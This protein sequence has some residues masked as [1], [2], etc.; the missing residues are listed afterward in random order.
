MNP[1]YSYA[2]FLVVLKTIHALDSSL[3]TGSAGINT[4]D[5]NIFEVKT[6]NY[7]VTV[8]RLDVHMTASTAPIQVWYRPGN[9]SPSYMDTYE[10]VLDT[11]I[12]GNGLNAMT[13]L[14]AFTTPIVI[15][16][17]STYT[18]Y[19]TTKTNGASTMY[20]EVGTLL[21]QAFASDEFLD[22]NEGY[23]MRYAFS[24]P[25]YPR[26]WNGVIYY[27]TTAPP[28]TPG[29]PTKNPTP[30]PTKLP[31]KQP[32]NKPTTKSPTKKPVILSS[33]PTKKPVTMIET[34]APTVTFI[35]T[36][37]PTFNDKPPFETLNPTIAHSK[38]PISGNTQSLRPTFSDT[39]SPT[40]P[41]TTPSPTVNVVD[42]LE[43]TAQSPAPNKPSP[44]PLP[45][46]PRSLTVNP[47]S[48]PTEKTP[49]S[50]TTKPVSVSSNQK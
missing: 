1:S 44:K 22:I 5:G 30:L 11:E 45:I 15:P 33:A 42:T 20:Y 17:D 29:S 14:P 18:F 43:P 46:D 24:S 4:I 49:Q 40:A 7:P 12:T 27:T 39:L 9:Q 47:T 34:L 16:A 19:V 6:K 36:L 38:M 28:A 23:A 2:A 26:K 50:P 13:P 3:S 41:S 25:A 8:N 31:T 37:A 21:G 48:N 10:N 32:T 35:E